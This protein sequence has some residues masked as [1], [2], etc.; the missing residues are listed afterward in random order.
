MPVRIT[1]SSH[2]AKEVKARYADSPEEV[3]REACP[4]VREQ[5][6]D[7]L[8]SSFDDDGLSSSIKQSSNGLVYSVIEAYSRHHHLILRPEDIWFAILTQFST[9][10]NK[11]AEE[12]RSQLVAHEGKKKLEIK[13]GSGDRFS[14]DFGVFAKEMSKLLEENIVD[15][16]LRDWI[17]P[18]FTT[19]TAN[20]SVIASILMMGAMQKYFSYLCT[21][22]CGLPSVTLLG[23][24]EDYEQILRRLDKLNSFGDEPAQFCRL[25]KPVLSRFIRSFEDPSDTTVINFWQRILDVN[26]QM[27]GMTIY[28]GWITAFCFW[29]EDGRCLYDSGRYFNDAELEGDDDDHE[30]FGDVVEERHAMKFWTHKDLHLKLDGVRYH[31]VDRRTIP[32]GWS[33]VPVMV[34]DNGEIVE[35]DMVAGSIGIACS[36]SGVETAEGRVTLDSM[37]PETGWWII[38][39]KNGH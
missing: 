37:Q 30:V 19:T 17:L 28:S 39:K 36:S 15:S 3:L 6:F 24:K 23:E 27:S 21:V 20:D 8:Q 26:N 38:E 5:S 34:D 22:C 18:S 35:T 7:L 33:K 31:K 32:P 9:Y 13:Y 14:V 16:D 29:N 11:N 12:L 10:I 1:P 25:L 2:G 4:N